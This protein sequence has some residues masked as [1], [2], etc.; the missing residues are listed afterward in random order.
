[1]IVIS[2]QKGSPGHALCSQGRRD[3]SRS[4]FRGYKKKGKI[5]EIGPL[6]YVV[7]GVT[8]LND[9]Q[10]LTQELLPALSSIQEK[11]LI[12]VVDL[13]LVKKGADGSVVMQEVS[14]L[15]KKELSI[16]GDIA[17]QLTGLLGSN[18]ANQH[19]SSQP[20]VLQVMPAPTYQPPQGPQAAAPASADSGVLAQLKLLGELHDSGVLTSEEFVR[21][22]NRILSC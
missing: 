1:M 10:Q 3:M 22:K 19:A 2:K 12:R 14:E 7:V 6:E 4:N 18:S 9:H 8:D 20:Q 5:M 11:G 15:D 17:D 13:I 21:E 16:Y